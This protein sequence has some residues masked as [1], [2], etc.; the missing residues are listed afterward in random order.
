MSVHEQMLTN[1]VPVGITKSFRVASLRI[2]EVNKTF[3]VFDRLTCHF[4]I[5]NSK[6]TG[7]A[8]DL[9]LSKL[10][11]GNFAGNF[12]IVNRVMTELRSGLGI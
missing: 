2:P 1:H 11:D 9:A 6:T 3:P 5:R 12:I 8:S 7:G 10:S 4:P